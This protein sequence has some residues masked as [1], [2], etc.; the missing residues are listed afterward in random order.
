MRSLLLE[1]IK[2]EEMEADGTLQLV[3]RADQRLQ[4]P[5]VKTSLNR[6][7][8]IVNWY[9]RRVR[10]DFLLVEWPSVNVIRQEIV[11]I[12]SLERALIGCSN[13]RQTPEI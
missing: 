2:M 13:V 6:A 10:P 8:D 1:E 7:A 9:S 12:R 5:F 4:I 11:Q 3:E